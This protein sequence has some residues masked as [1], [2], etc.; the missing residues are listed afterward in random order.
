MTSVARCTLHVARL[1]IIASALPLNAQVPAPEAIL[2]FTPGTERRLVEWPALVNYF[3]QLGAASDRVQFR[4]LGQTTLGAPFV[5]VVI[6]S[7]ANMA[8]LEELR[9]INQRLA[10][11]RTVTSSAERERLLRDGRTVVLITSSIH[12]TEVGAHLAPVVIADRLARGN[13]AETRRILD[14]TVILLVPSLNPDGVTI[15]S[16]WYNQTLGGPAEGTGPPELYHRYVGHDNNRDWYA[17]TQV[18]TQLTID[19]LHNAWRPHIVHDIHQ[20]GPFGSRYFI[21]PYLDPVEPNVDALIVAGFGTLGRH[22]AW[23]MTGQGKPGVVVDATY[24]AWTP[25]RA[26]QHYHGGVRILS[27]TASARLATSIE[28][29]ADRLR[30]GRG[31]DAGTASVNFPDPWRGGSWTL[32]NI[33]DYMASGALALLGHAAEHRATWLHNFVSIGQRAVTGWASWP[34]AFV[35]PADQDRA[36]LGRMLGILQRGG[37]EIRAAGA[38]FSAGGRTFPA[39]SWV[40]VLRQPYAAFAKALLE[41]QEYPDLRQYPG[42]PPRPPY[43]VTAHTLPLLMGVEVVTVQDSIPVLLSAPATLP[44]PSGVPSPR[45]ADRARVGLY[46][47]WTAPMDEGWTRWVFETEDVQYATVRDAD[48]RAGNLRRRFETIVIPQMSAN[49]ITRGLGEPYPD[50]LRGGLGPDGAAQLRRFVEEGGTLVT[51]DDASAWAIE[52]FELP[53]RNVIAGLP[54]QEFYAPGSIFRMELDTDHALTRGMPASTIAWFENS[55]TFEVL[56]ADRVRIIGRYPTNPDDVLLSGWV[57]GPDKVAGR[58][59]LVE[60]RVG[61][62]RVIMFGFRPQYRGQTLATYPLLFNAIR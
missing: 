62:G 3:Q 26:Y 36:R 47:S 27:E 38:G 40:I 48:M 54:S 17:F 43:D 37:V 1:A 4:V 12:S 33:V 44:V 34:Y 31:F 20:Q 58:A 51:L 59:A 15:V 52:A 55:P 2:G 11:P 42:G 32:A 41:V 56:D 10:D 25:A 22:M 16:R 46:Q 30:G 35:I 24:D 9:A 61:R 14:E 50:S 28:V 7:P 19:S 21:P 53:V 13:D 5:A 39:G 23:T 49:A 57:L 8:R 45:A 29:P 18:E 6:S 60:A